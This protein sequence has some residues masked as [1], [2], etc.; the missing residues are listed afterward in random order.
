M[1]HSLEIFLKIYWIAPKA[2]FHLN[3]KAL[4]IAPHRSEQVE[5]DAVSFYEYIDR[6]RNV[7]KLEAKL[8]GATNKLLVI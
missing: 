6:E 3:T 1:F 5:A 7:K 2:I 8:D 4:T